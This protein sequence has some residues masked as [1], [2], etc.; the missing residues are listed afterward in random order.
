MRLT[1]DR[2]RDGVFAGVIVAG[3]LLGLFID[4]GA[5]DSGVDVPARRGAVF[6]ARAVF[7]PPSSG[8]GSTAA[9]VAVGSIGD[10]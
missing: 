3:L 7:C 4:A 8:Q 1:S 5:D 6:S 2:I 9:Q 10:R